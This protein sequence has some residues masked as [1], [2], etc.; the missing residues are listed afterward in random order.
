[1]ALATGEALCEVASCPFRWAMAACNSSTVSSASLLET[2]VSP[3]LEGE[4]QPLE[5][6]GVSALQWAFASTKV[7]AR[8]KRLVVYFSMSSGFGYLA[9]RMLRYTDLRFLEAID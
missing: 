5:V 4:A 9:T 2:S 8:S 6:D 1:M 3:L 7:M